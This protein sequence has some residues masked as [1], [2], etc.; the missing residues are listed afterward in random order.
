MCEPVTIAMAVMAVA[1]I[2]MTA[3]STYSA[4]KAAKKQQ[5]R[6]AEQ[7]ARQV[8][9]ENR[10]AAFKKIERERE[11]ERA[12][13]KN[14]T[15]L[16]AMGLSTGAG[17]S[18]KLLQSTREASAISDLTSQEATEN[19]IFS[20]ESSFA[21]K[22]AA[23]GEGIKQRNIMAIKSGFNTAASAFAAGAGGGATGTYGSG[24]RMSGQTP[25]GSFIVGQS[26][27]LGGGV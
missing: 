3:Y 12:I 6:L 14:E 8:E 23:I 9:A 1:S 16:S 5:K 25:S 19:R 15:L 24:A 2:A 17:T 21:N 26:G 10:Q 27:A 18:A 22:S 7:T 11:T 4:N 20:L 13:G